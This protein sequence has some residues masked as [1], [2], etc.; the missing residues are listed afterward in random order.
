VTQVVFDP[1]GAGATLSGG[2]DLP[3]AGKVPRRLYWRRGYS[4]GGARADAD[5][6]SLV[7]DD[8][9]GFGPQSNID[10]LFGSDS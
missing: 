5:G 3:T 9:G 1:S 7:A 4:P 10:I 8:L 6:R 2:L